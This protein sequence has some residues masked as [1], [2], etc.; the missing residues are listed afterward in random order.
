MPA[1]EIARIGLSVT[2]D[3]LIFSMAETKGNVWLADLQ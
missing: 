2:R 1:Q 3:K